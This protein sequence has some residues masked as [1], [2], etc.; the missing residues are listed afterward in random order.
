MDRKIFWVLLAT[1]VANIA[2]SVIAPFLPI[3]FAAKG[4]NEGQ[5][6]LIFAVYSLAAILASLFV[7]KSLS[8]YGPANMITAG[9]VIMGLCFIAFGFIQDMTDA[10]KVFYFG[11]L[12]RFI[13]GASQ[14]FVLVTGLSVATNDYPEIKDKL[15]GWIECAVGLGLMVGPIIGSFLYSATNFKMTFLVYG[16]FLIVVAA[17]FKVKYPKQL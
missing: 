8:V 9:L 11:M 10:T 15:C 4:I 1:F 16:V 2:Y 13:Q 3:E 6:G 7:G 12:L 5:I 14:S 17:L